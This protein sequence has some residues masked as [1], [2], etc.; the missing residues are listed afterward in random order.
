M[1]PYEHT[2]QYMEGVWEGL[3]ARISNNDTGL[4]LDAWDAPNESQSAEDEGEG[5]DVGSVLGEAP[6]SEGPDILHSLWKG[7]GSS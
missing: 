1:F 2:W 3:D 7:N 4:E 5:I 6:I